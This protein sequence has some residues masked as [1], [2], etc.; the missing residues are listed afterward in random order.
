MI[1]RE[2]TNVDTFDIITKQFVAQKRL[3]HI[4]K[5]RQL[6]RCRDEEFGSKIQVLQDMQMSSSDSM[7]LT[8]QDVNLPEITT[9]SSKSKFLCIIILLS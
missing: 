7:F 1:E 2:K 3:D 5:L 8:L 6:I 4:A 9:S